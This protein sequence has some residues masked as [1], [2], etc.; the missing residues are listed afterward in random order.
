MEGVNT[1]RAVL[2]GGAV[3]A[4]AGALVF[5][6][7]AAAAVLSVGIAAHGWMWWYLRRSKAPGGQ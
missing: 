4:A 3:I 2:V 7:R 6:H 1:L 5:G